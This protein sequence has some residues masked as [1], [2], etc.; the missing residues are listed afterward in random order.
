MKTLTKLAK[1]AA[2]IAPF[3][4]PGMRISREILE[5][6]IS[7]TERVFSSFNI[8][9]DYYRS[10][11][12]VA[13]KTVI[14]LLMRRGQIPTPGVIRDLLRDKVKLQDWTEGLT[15][16]NLKKDVLTIAALSDEQ[17]TENHAGLVAALDD[18]SSGELMPLYNTRYPEIILSDVLKSQKICYFQLPVM[19][20]EFL[21]QSTG[22]LLLQSLRSAI[23]ELQVNATEKLKSLFSVYLD[24]FNDYIYPGFTT[25]L[26][27]SRSANIGVVFAHQSLGD[28]E[29]VGPDFKQAVLSLTNIKVIMQS[30][31][32]IS[33]EYFAQVVGTKTS[34]KTTERR[35]RFFLGHEDTGDQSVRKVEEYIVHPNIFKSDLSRGEGIVVIPHNHGK[36]VKRVQF[37]TVDME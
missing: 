17:F 22:K 26:N 33:A 29:K 23:S 28:L 24:D 1:S 12:Y 11:Q 2:H 8:T 25:L 32:P 30:N 7:D 27:K 15:D 34:E 36:T 19:Q 37:E 3:Q 31:D 6:H 21:A 5:R 35:R 4:L 14:T 18:F 9:H 20:Y 16:V 10:V 13:L